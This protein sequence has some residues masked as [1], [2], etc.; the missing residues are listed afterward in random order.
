MALSKEE[1]K[2]KQAAKE[3]GFRAAQAIGKKNEVRDR[4]DEERGAKEDIRSVGG[5]NR[6]SSKGIFTNNTKKNKRSTKDLMNAN[7]L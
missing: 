2:K 4:I 6:V 7:R 5:G 1:L 3:A